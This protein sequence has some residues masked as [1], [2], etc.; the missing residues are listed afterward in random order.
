ML[1]KIPMPL[2]ILLLLL[3]LWSMRL[4]CKAFNI[5]DSTSQ[6]LRLQAPTIMPN[7]RTIQ[8]LV[9]FYGFYASFLDICPMSYNNIN[10]R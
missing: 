10:L 3:L 7:A 6:E 9:H 5:P 1:C 2:G 8:V 4:L